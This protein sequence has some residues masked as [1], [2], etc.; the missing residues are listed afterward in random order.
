LAHDPRN[1]AALSGMGDLFLYTGLLDSSAAFYKAAIAAN[2][3]IAAAHNGLGSALY[4]NST[5]ALNPNFAMLRHIAD[6]ERFARNQF[7]SAIA[8]YT[9]AISLDSSQVQ[10][11]T[12]RGVLRDIHGDRRAAIEDYTLAIR[13]NPKSADAYSKRAG[14]MKSLGKFNDAIADYTA[15]INL[16]SSSYEFDPTTHFANA[17]FGRGVAFY[18]TGDLARAI[19]DFDSALAISPDHSL[20]MINRAVALIDEKKYDSAVAGFSRAIALLSPKEYGGALYL[21]YLQRGNSFKALQQYDKAITDYTV[22]R[23]SKKL[24][25]RACWRIA[26][27]FSLKNEAD[28]AIAWLEKSEAGGFTDYAAWRRDKQLSPLWNIKEFKELAGQ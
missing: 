26:E 10:A 12:N 3:R 9:A 16:D 17:Y 7:D 4:F 8:E 14:T 15:A 20:V 2:P 19:R 18:R 23:E 6:P 21:A 22:A 24:A 11:L 25:A 1:T 5:M 13:I 27:C 28:S